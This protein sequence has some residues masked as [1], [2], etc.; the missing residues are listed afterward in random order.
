LKLNGE[1]GLLNAVTRE[2]A[3]M[4][5]DNGRTN[6]AILLCHLAG[7][8]DSVITILNRSLAEALSVELGQ[9]P[10][11]LEPLKPRLAPTEVQQQQ[12]QASDSTSASMLSTDDPVELAQKVVALYDAN[13][14]W[15][16]KVSQVNRE[17]I[18]ILFN[19]NKAKKIIE[20][21]N[22]IGALDV[23]VLHITTYLP[24]NPSS[25]PLGGS[26]FSPSPPKATSAR[27]APKP[28]PSRPTPL[29]SRATLATCCSG[30]LAAVRGIAS[31]CSQPGLTTRCGVS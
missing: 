27:S 12:Q 5:D 14:L 10:L 26:R 19:L 1:N 30:A 29:K 16:R 7:E 13:S 28:T 25:R 11:R 9:E 31:T 20:E 22:Y 2:A 3:K 15:W 24:T 17:T 21:G 8:Y 23:S 4:A 18:G 6:D